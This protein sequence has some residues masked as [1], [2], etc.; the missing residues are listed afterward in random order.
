[1]KT[2]ELSV[3]RVLRTLLP[4]AIVFAL[5]A[6]DQDGGTAQAPAPQV[7]EAVA[8]APVGTA[9]AP[10]GQ[11][12]GKTAGKTAGNSEPVRVNPVTTPSISTTA[13]T[14]ASKAALPEA[15]SG[16]R[17]A[18][19][20]DDQNPGP[21]NSGI[22]LDQKLDMTL[23]PS[24]LVLGIMQP[25]VP[26]TG[27]VTITNNG[28]T[29]IQI[30]KAIASCGCTTPVWPRE[31]I[32]PGESAE[33]EITLKPTTKQGSK[34][35][36]RVTLQMVN[37]APQVI[38]VEGEVGLFVRMTPNFLDAGKQEE[39]DQQTIVLSSENKI[40]FSIISIE[41]DVFSGVGGEKKLDHELVMNW[42]SWETA[43]R[44]PTVK[45]ITDHPDAPELG[46]TVR[47]SITRE[48]PSAP[49]VGPNAS[50]PAAGRL[51]NAARS[52]DV[53]GVTKAI[54]AGEV[55]DQ[56]SIG[57]MSALHWAAREG[58]LEVVTVLVEASANP[59]LPNK[60]GKTPVALAAESGNLE[61][62]E[63]LV[64]MG[65]DIAHTDEIGGTPLLWAVAL[66][67]NPATAKYLVEQGASVNV[68]DKS[69]MTPLIWAAGIGQPESVAL[70]VQNGAD[71]DV[72]EI[73][74]K[75]T[76]L[77][78]A[79]RI[80]NPSS[81]R[82]LLDAKANIEIKNMLGQT[83]VMIA[84]SQGSLEKIKM[85]TDSGADLSVKDVRGWTVL[86][87]ARARVDANRTT[88]IEFLEANVPAEV[89]DAKPAVGG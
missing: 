34:L 33:L 61:V 67:K 75:E 45:I 37:G 36:K 29:P 42:E 31:P 53:D 40:P 65:G 26:K 73:H 32:G 28:D 72:V 89:K 62:L 7:T 58:N 66:S 83:A 39:S 51:V 19:T 63:F 80:G 46:V 47:R 88:V 69:G 87:H 84:A 64:S 71:L 10:A 24:T 1:M 38:T 30:K 5:A 15:P 3:T 79:A 54:E 4:A 6:C 52:G 56:P 13:S 35:S 57:G 9:A 11:A 23:T 82:I 22:D 68:V 43:G 77:M 8:A 59:N 76:A 81:V 21:R 12:A 85:L 18:P 55:V 2:Q 44:R 78:R 74:A 60:A 48:K 27:T 86:D 14:S 70:L 50:R 17:T 41:P 49:N 25:G 16:F 20:K